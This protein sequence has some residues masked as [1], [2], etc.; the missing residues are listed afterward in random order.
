M[1]SPGCAA[2]TAPWLYSGGS[3][4]S[5]AAYYLQATGRCQR[6][7]SFAR[8]GET[9][10]ILRCP[11]AD[12]REEET[13]EAAAHVPRPRQ[14]SRAEDGRHGKGDRRAAVF[15]PTLDYSSSPFYYPAGAT[16][17]PPQAPHSGEGLLQLLLRRQTRRRGGRLERLA[18]L[19]LDGILTAERGRRAGRRADRRAPCP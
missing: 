16:A 8:V 11:A 15:A 12:L 9:V 14:G 7:L 6:V 2:D 10:E 19:A 3:S 18:A 4:T 5:N 1:G 17:A 13:I